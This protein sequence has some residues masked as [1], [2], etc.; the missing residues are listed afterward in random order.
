MPEGEVTFRSEAHAVPAFL[1]N[2][3]VISMDECDSCNERFGHGCEDDLSKWSLLLRAASK[4]PGRKRR[5]KFK[6]KGV[7]EVSTQEDVLNLQFHSDGLPLKEA[8][9]EGGPQKLELPENLSGQPYVPIEAA[10]AL[11]KSACSVCPKEYLLQCQEAILWLLGKAPYDFSYFPILFSFTPGPIDNG[12]GEVILLRRVSEIAAPY[13]WGMIYSG[14]IRLQFFVPFCPADSSWF[15]ISRETT[16][17]MMHYPSK[18]PLGWPFGE[19][20]YGMMNWA[21]KD[22]VKKAAS[23]SFYVERTVEEPI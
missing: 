11:I 22:T 16:L 7:L 18:F 17:Q 21:G 14:N 6:A 5:P 10:K 9:R 19:V 20:K 8:L 13:F 1:G 4:T 23:V 15:Q 3:S 12:V 2:K